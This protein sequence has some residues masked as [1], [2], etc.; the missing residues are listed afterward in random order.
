MLIKEELI[1]IRIKSIDVKGIKIQDKNLLI[2]QFAGDTTLFLKDLIQIVVD[3]IDIDI[4]K[5][6][7]LLPFMISLL[8]QS[9]LLRLKMER[10][11][12]V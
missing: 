1:A 7:I 4:D 8:S 12:L 6:D 9:V 5:C 2:S 3:D 11:T 10:N